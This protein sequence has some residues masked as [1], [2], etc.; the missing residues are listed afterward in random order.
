[1]SKINWEELYNEQLQTASYLH[2]EL[3]FWRGQ[4][5]EVKELVNLMID[6]TLKEQIIFERDVEITAVL[7]Q[8]LLTLILVRNTIEKPGEI[9]AEI[10]SYGEIS[11]ELS[12]RVEDLK[13]SQN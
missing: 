6:C 12:K 11:K 10:E 5:E 4:Y 13:K 9:H 3:L 2:K 7:R 8:R 1:M